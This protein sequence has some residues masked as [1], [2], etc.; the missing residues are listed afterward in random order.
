MQQ[1]EGYESHS[2]QA[3]GEE[4]FEAPSKGKKLKN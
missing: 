4:F 3:G 2:P 1:R